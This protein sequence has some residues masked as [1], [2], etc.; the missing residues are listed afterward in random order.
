MRSISL[1]FF[2][3]FS[4]I[5]GLAESCDVDWALKV[6]QGS[7]GLREIRFCNT[8]TCSTKRVSVRKLETWRSAD[9]FILSCL[10]NLF[11]N[12][13]YSLI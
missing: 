3:L 7:T 10:A 1:I 12:Y 4:F 6:Q 5:P 2:T 9:V 13:Y 8:G 11:I